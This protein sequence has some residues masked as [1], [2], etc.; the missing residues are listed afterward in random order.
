MTGIKIK[1][2]EV[3]EVYLCVLTD[4]KILVYH[5]D[6]NNPMDK[7]FGRYFDPK[8]MVYRQTSIKYGQLKRTE[9]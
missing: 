3:G 7:A 6:M 1:D 8:D 2:L 4:I 9:K 5:V